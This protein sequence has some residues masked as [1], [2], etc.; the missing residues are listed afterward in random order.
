MKIDPA[1]KKFLSY[2]R[3]YRWWI[4]GATLCGLLKYNIPVLFPWILKD[5]IDYLLTA[6]SP[7]ISRINFKIIMLIL[8][9]FLWTIVT[10]FRSYLADQ[11]GQRLIFDLRHELYVHLQRMSMGFYENR[12][13]GAIASRLL[14]DISIAQN[15]EGAITID[16]LDI[17]NFRLKS[18]RRQIALVPQE[19][20]LFSG[21]IY[22][23]II[24]GKQNAGEDEVWDAAISAN[25]HE[26]IMEMPKGYQTGIGEGGT[27]L[28]GGQRQRI[29][30]A[31]AFLKK[32]AHPHFG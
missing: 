6:A 17:R 21:N 28:S 25:A 9:Y 10:Y 22:E 14:G 26:F 5:V 7:D 4:V 32:R 20:V 29:A 23:N 27:K 13:I 18:L 24:M 11:A 3:P 30:L 31:R 16:G 2:A 1:L 15:T 8:A 12:Q 19:P